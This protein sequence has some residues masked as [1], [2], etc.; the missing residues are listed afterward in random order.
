MKRRWLFCLEG[1]GF[2]LMNLLMVASL[3][4]LLA[5]PLP[6]PVSNTI[7]AIGIAFHS[8]AQLREDGVVVVI[9]YSLW[10]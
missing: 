1:R 2:R 7:P 10:L 8:L 6:I 3:A 9:G 5:L 4:F